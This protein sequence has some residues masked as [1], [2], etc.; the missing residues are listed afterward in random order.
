M[1]G[2]ESNLNRCRQVVYINK[3]IDFAIRCYNIYRYRELYTERR[4]TISYDKIVIYK[5]YYH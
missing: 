3:L 1:L 5:S 4:Y 2:D